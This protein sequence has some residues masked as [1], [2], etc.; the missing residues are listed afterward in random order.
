M[1]IKWWLVASGC[2]SN[3]PDFAEKACSPPAL[4]GILGCP[5]PV[6]CQS[7]IDMKCY[8]ADGVEL[9]PGMTVWVNNSTGY[10]PVQAIVG[11]IVN[12]HKFEYARPEVHGYAG[13]RA[14]S[15]WVSPVKAMAYAILNSGDGFFEVKRVL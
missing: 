9:E 4:A 14:K 13:A 6:P 7:K 11:K 2:R 5:R 12:E 10:P 1:I 3:S 15:T 8:S